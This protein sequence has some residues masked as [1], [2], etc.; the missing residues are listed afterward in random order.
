MSPQENLG[1]KYPHMP[2][3]GQNMNVFKRLGLMLA[4]SMVMVNAIAQDGAI[5][6]DIDG[7][8]AKAA[9]DPAQRAAIESECIAALGSDK[10]WHDRYRAVRILS[11]IG[12]QQSIAPLAALLLD[13]G[14]S[15]LART[16][17]E[18]MPFAEVDQLFKDSMETAPRKVKLGLIS[19][20]AARKDK[21]A[22]AV[23]TAMAAT[24]DKQMLDHIAQALGKIG[25]EESRGML[26]A[27]LESGDV[28][29]EAMAAEAF[30]LFADTLVAE[31][32]GTEAADVYQQLLDRKWQNHIR[33][34]ALT[35][36]LRALPVQA[37]EALMQAI[38]S[39]DPLLRDTAIAA[40]ATLPGTG[41]S[42]R[43]ISE[44]PSL[45]PAVQ[46][47]LMESLSR[48]EE[49][50]APA[51]LYGLLKDEREDMRVAALKAI[52]GQGD[53]TAI[54][55]VGDLLA[56]AEGRE[57]KQ[58]AIETLRR[59][60]GE[61]IDG[62]LL[63]YMTA[64][65]APQRPD[66]IEALV[67]RR[68][69]GVVEALFAQTAEEAVRPAAFNGLARLAGAGDVDA[70]LNAL[71]ALAGEAGRPEAE[72]AVIAVVREAGLKEGALTI[73]KALYGELPG[74]EFKDVTGKVREQLKEGALSIKASNDLFG[75]AAPGKVK[76]L[77]IEY[78][79]N[80]AAE[81][82]T[83]PEN[84]MLNIVSQTITPELIAKLT[85]PLDDPAVSDEARASLFRILSRLGGN[86]A[87]AAV[88]AHLN[89]ETPQLRDAAV[90]AAGAWPEPVAAAD[91]AEV[92]ATT[93]DGGHRGL[94]LRGCVRL[95]RLNALSS[96]ETSGLYGRL[97]T[98][99]TSAEERK[100]VLSGLAEFTAPEAVALVHPC[101][102][103]DAVKE[104]AALALEALKARL[105]EEAYNNAVA[106]AAAAPAAASEPAGG[107]T[108][109]SI[110]NGADLQGWSGDA[111][112]WRVEE[113]AI[114]GETRAE[115]KLDYNT[116]LVW[117]GGQPA[118][119]TI[120]FLYKLESEWANSGL[121]FRSEV[122]EPYRVRGYQADIAQ[123]DW[124]TG[125]CYEEGGRGIVARRGQ[126]TVFDAEGKAETTSFAEE[127]A[128]KDYIYTDNWN[129]YEVQVKGN[130]FYGRI[131]GHKMHEVIDDSPQARKS[132]SIA[133]Q[134]HAGPPMKIRIKDILLK[135]EKAAE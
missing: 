42:A 3:K 65:P 80:G 59:L 36:L 71:V 35:G 79:L 121:Q 88:K 122:F 87:Y 20:M 53:V 1:H 6:L 49:A 104:E 8:V 126:K 117:E 40:V 26:K 22:V 107:D 39:D 29:V 72:G 4:V 55:P 123:E 115:P 106:A 100:L 43:V 91:L 32:Q 5:E 78:T 15:H 110:F 48:R 125:I 89:S 93:P 52:A 96:E 63:Q 68:A 47:P 77:Q 33:A 103:D 54:P 120:K 18:V 38:K 7:P 97:M 69:P 13:E 130:R 101:L 27:M 28:H 112:L 25:G 94:A 90:R 50:M 76:R 21:G 109:V 23:L 114:V 16:A 10:P 81:K 9:A 14:T 133:F 12:T 128:L 84:G 30:M 51:F 73:Y 66:L 60:K 24:S 85:R 17:L 95:L 64:A 99:A 132:G 113:G 57:E 134:L 46:L 83:V 2:G 74:G 41:M 108:F 70:L 118:D 44:F 58:S 67:Q 127:N 37:S 92:F 56:A 31:G 98:A 105:G 131:N 86:D 45:A 116:F 102:N 111:A 61:D 11:V 119:F 62:A 19:A 124:I 135:T 129:E 75:D 82:R 34:G